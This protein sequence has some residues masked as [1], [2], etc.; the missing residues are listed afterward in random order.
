M[1]VTSNP[2]GPGRHGTKRATGKSAGAKPAE[3]NEHV[4]SD[5]VDRP[6]AGGCPSVAVQQRVGILSQRHFGHNLTDPDR[7]DADRLHTVLVASSDLRAGLR[8]GGK[9]TVAP[10]VSKGTGIDLT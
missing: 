8:F 3:R 10:R 6:A 1:F 4:I 7:A 2:A 5:F 9:S